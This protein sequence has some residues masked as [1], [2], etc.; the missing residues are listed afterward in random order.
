MSLSDWEL[1]ACARQQIGQHG[2]D[3]ELGA[4]RRVDELLA[5][6]DLDGHR[7]WVAILDRISQ[8]RGSQPG[9]TRH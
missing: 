7:T 2:A 3:A 1:W 8:L 9:E 4:A 5:V 6:G